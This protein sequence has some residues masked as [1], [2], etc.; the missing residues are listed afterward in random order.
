MKSPYREAWDRP[1]YRYIA[2]SLHT[3]AILAITEKKKKTFSAN[4]GSE[5]GL[6]H[7]RAAH[8]ICP[9][10][11]PAGNVKD[12]VSFWAEESWPTATPDRSSSS[13]SAGSWKAGDLSPGQTPC[14]TSTSAT[15]VLPRLPPSILSR[16]W[17]TLVHTW[18]AFGWRIELGTSSRHIP[19][20][21]LP[22]DLALTHPFEE[23]MS[24]TYPA[25]S[26]LA[27]K[28]AFPSL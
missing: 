16:Q 5:S 27:V 2:C 3:T 23:W 19:A 21:A 18:W 24:W 12:T 7:A 9:N 10:I 26:G 28:L 22:L 1:P 11:L 6:Q 4:L 15:V 17:R 13:L 25:V 14:H 8:V 20:T